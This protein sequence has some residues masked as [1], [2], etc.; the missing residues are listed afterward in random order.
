MFFILIFIIFIFVI[1]NYIYYFS[2]VFSKSGFSN[3]FFFYLSTLVNLI[4]GMLV[5]FKIYHI[6]LTKFPN[7]TFI[8][9]LA[10]NLI[11]LNFIYPLIII[12]LYIIKKLHFMLY[13]L[14]IYIDSKL[15]FNRIYIFLLDFINYEFKPFLLIANS[16]TFLKK[17]LYRNTKLLKNILLISYLLSIL[18]LV[19]LV[20]YQF[21][22]KSPTSD[23]KFTEY[24]KSDL[25]LYTQV[26]LISTLPIIY[27]IIKK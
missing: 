21:S 27:K 10:L 2:R 14:S 1:L 9:F 24:F 12:I 17:P 20:K 11:L 6:L 7:F 16:N 23:L 18:L 5:I 8:F 19:F 4:Y 15:K 13:K 25:E 3:K 26:F 22:I